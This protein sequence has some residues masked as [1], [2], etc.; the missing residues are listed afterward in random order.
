MAKAQVDRKG[1][2]LDITQVILRPIVTEKSTEL[3]ESRNQYTF[4]VHPYA[5]KA[6]IRRAVEELFG[7]R[8]VRVRVLKRP[9]K[10]RRTRFRRGR[11]RDQK[12]AIVTLHPEDRLSFA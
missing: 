3:A 1:P 8:V 5:D 2:D 4:E 7:V 11:T 6:L 12:K 10:Q 9:G